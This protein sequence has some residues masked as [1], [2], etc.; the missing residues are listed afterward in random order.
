MLGVWIGMFSAR[1]GGI[2]VLAG[3][4]GRRAA[5][6]A[7]VCRLVPGAAPEPAEPSRKTRRALL[8]DIGLATFIACVGLASQPQALDA[9]AS[10]YGMSLPLMGVGHRR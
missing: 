3:H 6:A 8:K 4:G 5:H 1:F 2:A 10:K 7:L 9:G